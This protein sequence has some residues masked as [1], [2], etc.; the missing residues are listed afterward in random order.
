[1]ITLDQIRLLEQ[2]VE[3][4]VAK[5][6]RLE[7]ENS[8]LKQRCQQLEN[9]KSQIK[10]TL[11]NFEQDQEKIEQGIINALDRLNTV[12]NSVLQAAGI[13]QQ[14]Q[15]TGISHQNQSFDEH[16]QKEQTN[17]LSQGNLFQQPNDNAM[18][19]P[20]ATSPFDIF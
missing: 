6:A 13:I 8:E 16:P 17:E 12:E 20:V 10:S 15:P 4:A 11:Y 2:K 7:A 3:S 5:I 18:E 1:M 9:E 19:A 14:E